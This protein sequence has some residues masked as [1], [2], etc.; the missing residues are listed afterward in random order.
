MISEHVLRTGIKPTPYQ[1][2]FELVTST[3]SGAVNFHGG[4]KQFSFLGISLVYDKSDQHTS[5]YDSY[6]VE[7]ARTKIKSTKL[8]NA[9]NTYSSFNSIKFDTDDTRDKFLLSN[10][11][12]AWYCKGSSIAQFPD[13]ACNPIFQE[14][15]TQSQ[16]FTSAHKKF[17]INLRCEKSYTNEIEKLNRDDSNLLVTIMLKNAA[18]KKMRLRVTGFYQGKYLYLLSNNGLI[19]NYK[20]YR[21]KKNKKVQ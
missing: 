18:V 17:F 4:N 8:E 9:S 7:L 13:Y 15:P 14:L 21:V 10:Q 16:Y 11:F 3:Q 19:M 20:E 12:V 5:I 1:K 6:N 2:S